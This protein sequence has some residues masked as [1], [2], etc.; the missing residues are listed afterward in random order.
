[1]SSRP[2]TLQVANI[3]FVDDDRDV[4]DSFGEILRAEGHYVRTANNG[5]DGLSML[6]AARLPDLVV[7]DVDMPILDG[8]AMA[9]RMLL[10]DAGEEKIPVVLV[11]AN[12]ALP[13]IAGRMGTP[14][15]IRKTGDI[16]AF[17]ELIDRAVREHVSPS[18]A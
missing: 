15:F 1:M 10:H 7:L 14:Y 3:L 11:S 9:H 4:A 5:E 8:P 6:K 13:E 18:A 2:T 16:G 12:E 17:L